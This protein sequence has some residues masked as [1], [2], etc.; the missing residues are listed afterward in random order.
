MCLHPSDIRATAHASCCIIQ[1]DSERACIIVVAAPCSN[2]GGFRFDS[3]WK[4]ILA[5]VKKIP[6]PL[7]MPKHRFKT[8]PSTH[9]GLCGPCVR[10]GEG[11]GDSLAY[12][13]S[14][15]INA[16]LQEAVL[17]LGRPSFF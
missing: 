7:H 2:S 17:P 8:L 1:S 15:S 14:S 16:I 4:G 6:L 11:F 13:R 3:L 9:M 10:V 12:V 5:L